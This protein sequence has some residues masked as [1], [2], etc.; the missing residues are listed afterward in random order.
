MTATSE[1]IN[2]PPFES[3][4]GA[5]AGA[6]TEAKQD[7]IITGLGALQTELNQKLEP[8]QSVTA[9]LSA[10][11]K[12]SLENLRP[13]TADFS[14]A[15]LGHDPEPSKLTVDDAQ[16]L[17]VRGAVTCDEG[18]FTSNASGSSPKITLV[19]TFTFT[20]GSNVVDGTDII[21]NNPNT[22]RVGDYV[23]AAGD[24]DAYWSRILGFTSTKIT[25][26]GNY[27]G[28]GGVGV[29]CERSTQK[30]I[31]GA[32]GS[33]TVSAASGQFT[34]ASGTISGSITGLVRYV[35]YKPLRFRAKVSVSAR[36][37]NQDIYIGYGESGA[38]TPADCS[39]FARFK[40]TGTDAK[41]LLCEVGF[42]A[43]AGAPSG[44]EV[45][46]KTIT[47][48]T[49]TQESA[50]P[51]TDSSLYLEVELTSLGAAFYVYAE[52]EQPRRFDIEGTLVRPYSV[53]D[54]HV[55][56][57]NTGVPA[58][59]ANV[60]VD[61]LTSNNAN[62]VEIL[63]FSEDTKFVADTPNC[64][65]YDA[66]TV[67]GNNQDFVVIDMERFQ[68]IAL[69]YVS[70]G[71]GCTIAVQ[72]SN[73]PAFG[74]TITSAMQPMS[75]GTPVTSST[76]VGHWV[77]AKTARYLRVR[78]TA[79]TSGAPSVTVEAYKTPIPWFNQTQTAVVSATNLSCNNAQWAGQTPL[80]PATNGSTNRAL[81]AGIA[82]PT[83]NT[84]YSAQAWAAASGSGAT[85]AEA[86]G[87]GAASA[88]DVNVTA[89]TAGSSVGLDVYLQESPDNGS[90][91]WYDIWQCEALTAISR[92]RIPAIP[93]GGRRR[94]RWVNRGGAATTA[95]VTVTATEQ[96]VAFV[97][98]VQW[99]DRTASVTSGTA[100][101]GNGAAYDIAGCKALS[102]VIQTGTATAPASFKIQ[103]SMNGV[104][105]YDA[106]AATSCPASSMTIIPLTAGVYG[107][108]ARFVC[109]VAGT[110]ALVSA[111]HIYG[112]N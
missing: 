92:A 89:W 84:D 57:V 28:T 3:G 61:M 82:G 109:T 9:D 72:Q 75:G 29:S 21:D 83:T 7:V 15:P 73:D 11:D 24:S 96:S 50:G 30:F 56:V 40:L 47:L 88:F 4:G 63:G 14:P 42:T 104:D 91:Q 103:M 32:G 54:S 51:T 112:T 93:V 69:Q 16:Q 94:M 95:T 18:S 99:F 108:F 81:V 37:A 58:G 71:G 86:N 74:A 97:K 6:A 1:I 39:E 26:E 53:M 80:S 12:L 79:Y 13:D 106:S 22:L 59:N 78:S 17:R 38:A 27:A 45:R 36:Q 20:N 70:I 101:T 33:I 85:I 67:P 25:L 19:G 98:Q 62:V 23:K 8:G 107:R 55:C 10:S 66:K 77:V 44:N 87:L 68:W 90:A 41:V 110:S 105:W 2:V 64:V 111:G 100:G 52:G 60:V 43:V 5:G 31:I 102:F 76:A 65:R 35:D 46:K 48:P 34:I 49:A